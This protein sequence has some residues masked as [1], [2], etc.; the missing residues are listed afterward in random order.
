[1]NKY[2]VNQSK[3]NE[4]IEHSF[5]SEEVKE[6]YAQHYAERVKM[7]NHSFSQKI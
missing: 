6:I 2:G 3:V 7:L 4:L 5:L 1:M